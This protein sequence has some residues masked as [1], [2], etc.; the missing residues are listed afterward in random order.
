MARLLDAFTPFFAFGLDVAAAIEAGGPV[1]PASLARRQAHARLEAARRVARTSGHPARHIESACFA[2][3]AWFDELARSLPG[4]GDA[5][6][7][8]HATLFNSSNAQTEFFHHLSALGPDEAEVREVYWYALALGF[9]GQYYFEDSDGGE[10]GKLKALHGQQLPVPPIA[11]DTLAWGRLTPQPYGSPEPPARRRPQRRRRAL[12]RVGGALALLFPSVYLASL[13][14][15]GRPVVPLAANDRVAQ[16]LQRY[17]CA[18]LALST[19][20]DG[21]SH[22]SGFV[23]STEEVVRVQQEV[24]ALPDAAAPDFDL[25]IRAWPYCEVAAILKPYQMRNRDSK[26][27]LQVL[28][29]SASQGRLREGDTV[30][31]QVTGPTYGSNLRVDYYTSDGAVLH[32]VPQ[33]AS[34]RLNPRQTVTLGSDMP[35]SWL[36][37]PPFGTVLVAVLASSEPFAGLADRPPFELASAYLAALRESIAVNPGGS[38][39]VADFLFLETVAR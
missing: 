36:V 32:L 9:R 11:L 10:R 37:S 31:I 3:A 30:R 14:L 29:L 7:S 35:T 19:G 21:R 39:L 1:L 12:V 27:G 25:R 38:R 24:A 17:A 5:G 6:T 13:L 18:D 4:A 20:T 8:L 23:A 2:A 33:P 26:A 22:V 28:A 15:G 16:Q 34:V